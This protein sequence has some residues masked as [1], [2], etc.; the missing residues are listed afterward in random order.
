MAFDWPSGGPSTAYVLAR[1]TALVE[2]QSAH[3]LKAISPPNKIEPCRVAPRSCPFPTHGHRCRSCKAGVACSIRM[4]ARHQ[5]S[6]LFGGEAALSFLADWHPSRVSGRGKVC[7]RG[8]PPLCQSK[9]ASEAPNQIE[10]PQPQTPR[11]AKRGE[12][13]RA[14][15]NRRKPE[16]ETDARLEMLEALNPAVSRNPGPRSANLDRPVINYFTW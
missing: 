8:C 10:P 15:S 7:P 6:I 9:V 3:K 14:P 5:G 2:G 16:Q 4:G 13:R 11:K 12:S 1:V